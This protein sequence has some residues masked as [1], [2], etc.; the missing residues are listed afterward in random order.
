MYLWC[1]SK[2]HQLLKK[3]KPVFTF[4]TQIPVKFQPLNVGMYTQYWDVQ[5]QPSSF[6][7]SL[8]VIFYNCHAFYL[9]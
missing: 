9:C 1:Y 4:L 6:H 5:V 8:I 3:M 7:G 2:P